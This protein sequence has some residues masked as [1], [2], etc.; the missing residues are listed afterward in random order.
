MGNMAPTSAMQEGVQQ[1]DPL[2]PMLFILAMDSLQ[3]LLDQAI[4][5]GIKSTSNL[6]LSELG[7][8]CPNGKGD[9]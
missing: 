6:S 9:G 3:R 5:Q 7:K 2:S 8:G 4:Q 1:G